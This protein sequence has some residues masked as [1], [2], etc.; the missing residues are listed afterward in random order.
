MP[1]GYAGHW[2]DTDARAGHGQKASP[3]FAQRTHLC[4]HMMLWLP[5]QR[6]GCLQL[7]HRRHRSEPGC[8]DL[9][10]ARLQETQIQLQ[11]HW[12]EQKARNSPR[13]LDMLE[14]L[15][16]PLGFP[17]KAKT[18]K[19]WRNLESAAEIPTNPADCSQHLCPTQCSGQ[20]VLVLPPCLRITTCISSPFGLPHP[21]SSQ[22][23]SCRYR[24]TTIRFTIF[25]IS[26][27][28]CSKS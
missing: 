12:R 11:S 19:Q 4:S 14:I 15:E 18:G 17:G 7:S 3:A 13:L 1:G 24:S 10:H 27:L 25:V 6:H 2:S 22:P 5:R 21:P 9:H 16:T 23:C 28:L 8:Q 26:F 20:N